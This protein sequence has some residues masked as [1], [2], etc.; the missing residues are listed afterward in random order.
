MSNNNW[1]WKI[2]FA[3]GPFGSDEEI[4][5][6]VIDQCAKTSPVTTLLVLR[7]IKGGG[8]VMLWKGA[9][10]AYRS[11][12]SRCESLEDFADNE[13]VDEDDDD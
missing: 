9:N 2:R 8:C 10:V 5:D 7:G 4:L 3:P 11:W 13:N 12:S 1:K 6:H